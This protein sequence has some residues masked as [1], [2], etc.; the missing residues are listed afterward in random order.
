MATHLAGDIA[1]A[2]NSVSYDKP[3]QH[4]G[5]SVYRVIVILAMYTKRILE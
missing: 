2:L 5:S 4:A 3:I 1:D